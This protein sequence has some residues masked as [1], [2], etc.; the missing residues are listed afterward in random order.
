MKVV[1][2]WAGDDGLTVRTDNWP[3][4]SWMTLSQNG[5]RELTRNTA[6]YYIVSK[7]YIGAI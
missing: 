1:R 5:P 4:T 2:F 3:E 7:L 6:E